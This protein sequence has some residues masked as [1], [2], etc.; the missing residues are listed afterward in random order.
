MVILIIKR[1][2]KLKFISNLNM[3]KLINNIFFIIIIFIFVFSFLFNA[4]NGTH[5]EIC[6]N[7]DSITNIASN[8]W[9]KQP[10]IYNMVSFPT[11]DIEKYHIT[12]NGLWNGFI[13]NNLS[14]PFAFGRL[15]EEAFN[16]INY[17]TDKEFVDAQHAKGMLVPATILTTQGHRSFQLDQF[18]TLASRSIDGKLC[19]WDLQ[20]DSYWMNA[21][22][23][24]FIDWC[25]QHGKKA[26]DA[27]ADMI[28]LDEIQGNSF[29]PL[30]QW[31]SQYTGNPAPGFSDISIEAFRDYL[32]AKYSSTEL[33]EL[34]DINDINTFD[35]K[36]RIASTMNYTYYNRI[37][38]DP[39]FKDYDIFLETSNFEAKK[40]L[41]ESLRS[42][43]SNQKKEIVISANSY[44]LGTNQPF[45]FWPK[46]L[47][48]A[49][50]IDMFTFENTYTAVQDQ[51]IPTFYQT[52]WLAWERLAYAATN[53]PAVIIIDT[54]TVQEIN[55]K[56]IP[57]FGF[58]NRLGILCAEAFANKGSFVNYHFQV[59]SRKRNWKQVEKIHQFV[60]NHKEFYNYISE[61]YGS[62]AVLFLYGEG[63]REHMNTY[64]GCAQ[65]LS[66]SHIPYEVLFDGD[67]YYIND[68]ISLTN[69]QKFPLIIIPSLLNVTNNQ[70]V[71][72]L[73][74]VNQGGIAI[75]FDGEQI[76]F[77]DAN[78]EVIHGNGK[79]YV[80]VE[81]IGKKY[82]ETYIDEYRKTISN[83][84]KCYLNDT[85]ILSEE[86][87][88]IIATPYINE[89]EE[90]IVHLVNYDHI[91]LFDFIWPHNNIEIQI[92]MPD[93]PLSYIQLFNTDGSVIELSYTI[94]NN[95][96][97]FTVPFLKDYGLVIIS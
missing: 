80:F 54:K 87:R 40:H 95:Y 53:S 1:L 33:K 3:K 89:N 94:Q 96:L 26:I 42:Y 13:G 84:I 93:F 46:G 20:A 37:Q 70:L 90:I 16:G 52:K 36:N 10:Q 71:T 17:K 11:E 7:N 74:Y 72:I 9:F 43:A 5:R 58:S 85:I 14:S 29:I 12:V 60:M 25:I 79:F 56:N 75:I 88:K 63:M 68:S 23:P 22:N 31:S 19:P 91:G 92:R 83:A 86:N 8:Q 47:L 59:S 61:P 4:A 45:G 38:A 27:G 77:P 21:N 6:V 48:F 24:D 28:V 69:L 66:E 50:L 30:Y 65:A 97:L 81:D 82:F 35:L 39:L 44:A 34:Y 62:V 64:L 41:I 32:Q 78:G 76:G 73:Q 51:T 49:D 55:E 67:G 18:D 15:F 57:F 2:L